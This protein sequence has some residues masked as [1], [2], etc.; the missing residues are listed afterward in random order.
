MSKSLNELNAELCRL[1]SNMFCA[2]KPM[3]AAIRFL[4]G[5]SA[6]DDDAVAAERATARELY[7][8]KKAVAFLCENGCGEV[9]YFDALD[10]GVI[11]VGC[12][13]GI[14]GQVILADEDAACMAVDWLLSFSAKAGLPVIAA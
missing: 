10:A 4:R 2:T 14:A 7:A 1:P 5:A 9:D 11:P 8:L 12:V 13:P 6:D 3:Y